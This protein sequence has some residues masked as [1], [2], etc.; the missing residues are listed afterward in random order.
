MEDALTDVVEISGHHFSEETG[1]FEGFFHEF[2]VFFLAES[3]DLREV[4]EV[5][6]GMFF[7]SVALGIER[8]NRGRN[9]DDGG[10]DGD[11]GALHKHGILTSAEGD[12]DENRVDGDD[13]LGT[14]IGQ[15][16]I[17]DVL[18]H[19]GRKQGPPEEGLPTGLVGEGFFFL[20]HL[21]RGS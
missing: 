1:V 3:L 5:V 6:V 11:D 19:R 21:M 17:A 14:P 8:K 12:G 13:G 20:R 15:A 9:T 10:H 4:Q 7:E 2:Q 16:D 18:V